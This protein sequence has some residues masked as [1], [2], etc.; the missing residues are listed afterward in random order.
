MSCRNH[1][2]IEAGLDHCYRCGFRFCEECRVE[3]QGKPHCAP[4]K[5]EAVSMLESGAD[6]GR[7]ADGGELPPWER[8]QELGMAAAFWATIKA[9]MSDPSR[10]FRRMDTTVTT[11]DCLAVPCVVGV[12]GAIGGA[13]LQI[14]L[15][16]ALTG[17]MGAQGNLD[18]D[19]AAM[20]FLPQV[21]GGC[22]GIVFAPVFSIIGVFITA[23]F[24]HLFLMMTGKV[25]APFHQTM[26]G[27]CYA[28]A[29][30][31][32]GIIPLLGQ[33][34]GGLWS[35]WI[36]VVMIKELHR[37]TWGTA[38]MSVLWYIALICIVCGGAYALIFGVFMA[39]QG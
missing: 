7:G 9:V 24:M 30:S 27:Y 22:G 23:G 15:A 10:F 34:V 35:L 39:S 26:R 16:G 32:L 12:L 6:P 37:T 38:W 33:I 14:A 20:A 11:W 4:C 36:S 25:G 5:A 31:I 13:V 3:F 8:R 2:Q 28:Q 18:G 21:L 1:P 17:L 19:Q 29:P